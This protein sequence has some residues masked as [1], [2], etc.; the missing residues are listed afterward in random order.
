MNKRRACSTEFLDSLREATFGHQGPDAQ[1]FAAGLAAMNRPTYTPPP[2]AETCTNL[3]KRGLYR[4]FCQFWPEKSNLRQA[5]GGVLRGP[6][7]GVT[8]SALRFFDAEPVYL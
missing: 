5:N 1:L 6:C 8:R 4:H 2:G 7:C 3:Q